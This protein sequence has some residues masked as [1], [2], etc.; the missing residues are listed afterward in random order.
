MKVSNSSGIA[1]WAVM[2]EQV[3]ALKKI[4]H[5]SLSMNKSAE[6]ATLFENMQHLL[7]IWKWKCKVVDRWFKAIKAASTISDFFLQILFIFQT[8]LRNT[9]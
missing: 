3:W 6:G 7:K 8:A 2:I 9:R 5:G 1:F 4:A